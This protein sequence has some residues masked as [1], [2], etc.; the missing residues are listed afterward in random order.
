M[1]RRRRLPR[2]APPLLER[3]AALPFPRT[4]ARAERALLDE[5]VAVLEAA[6]DAGEDLDDGEVIRRVL[7]ARQDAQARRLASN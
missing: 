5:I 7:R 3:V 6:R 4:S 2:T 1:S